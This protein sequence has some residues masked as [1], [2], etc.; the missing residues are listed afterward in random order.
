MAAGVSTRRYRTTL[1]E[2]PDGQ[3]E[4]GMGKSSVSRRFVAMTEKH[5]AEWLSE[6]IADLEIPS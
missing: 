6:P 4:I 2:L 3:R 5:M 1:Y